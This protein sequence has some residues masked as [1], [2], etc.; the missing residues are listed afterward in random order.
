MPLLLRN[1]MEVRK[2]FL[3]YL[4]DSPTCPYA[5]VNAMFARDE[6]QSDVGNLPHIHMMLS[7][8]FEHLSDDQR[9]K[10]DDLI[11]ASICDIVRTDEVQHLIDDGIFTD[12]KDYEEMQKDAGNI[13]PHI[14]NA[15]CK[16]RVDHKNCPSDFKCRKTNNLKMS[17]DNTKHCYVQ[18][19]NEHT[20]ECIQRLIQIGLIKRV[21]I[22]EE[23]TDLPSNEYESDHKF[24]YPI[25]HIP[26]PIL[27]TTV[28]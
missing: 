23:D 9:K 26:R 6:Y 1:W 25:R 10:I 7:M 5:P 12:T 22:I 27:R 11:R 2:L 16:K 17:P 18:L 20:P 3:E 14:C 8:D 21:N 19:P 24:F 13:L 4:Y 28:T 15:R